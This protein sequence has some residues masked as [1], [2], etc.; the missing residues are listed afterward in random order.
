MPA[1]IK[2]AYKKLINKYQILFSYIELVLSIS[3]SLM[4][5]HLGHYMVLIAV[6]SSCKRVSFN[7]PYCAIQKSEETRFLKKLAKQQIQLQQSRL[8]NIAIGG[9]NFREKKPQNIMFSSFSEHVNA[10]VRRA[11]RHCDNM[12][13]NQSQIECSSFV[14]FFMRKA[15]LQGRCSVCKTSGLSLYFVLIPNHTGFVFISLHPYEK[16]TIRVANSHTPA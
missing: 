7:S 11:M 13:I 16:P 5:S 15:L 1:R 6:I 9:F 2:T 3:F 14:I 8:Y 12:K 4:V 10:T